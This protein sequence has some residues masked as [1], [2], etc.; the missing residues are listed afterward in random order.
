MD[1]LSSKSRTMCAAQS[2]PAHATVK[3]VQI[4]PAQYKKAFCTRLKSIRE[5][6]GLNQDD[7]AKQLGI[8]RDTYAKYESRSLLPHHLIPR[9]C[10]IT[11]HDCW[12]VLTGQP[13]S[14]A[15]YK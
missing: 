15:P 1:S 3:S 11:G 10:E 8:K 2:G 9:V 6:T 7:F 4:T 12:F 5:A 14:K 13:G